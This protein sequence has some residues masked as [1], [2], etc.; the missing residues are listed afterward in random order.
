MMY[1]NPY[2]AGERVI[3][4]GAALPS[5]EGHEPKDFLIV[6]GLLVNSVLLDRT[7][8]T[9]VSFL[10][11]GMLVRHTGMSWPDVRP[12]AVVRTTVIELSEKR[13]WHEPAVRRAYMAQQHERLAKAEL[14]AACNAQH[15]LAG[16]CAQWLVQLRT[17]LGDVLPITHA[18]LATLLGV[19][20]AG[21]SVMLEALQRA[22]VVVLQ[23]GSIAITDPVRLAKFACPCP[24]PGIATAFPISVEVIAGQ[25]S[26]PMMPRSLVER[27]VPAVTGEGDRT[28]ARREAALRICQAVLSHGQMMLA[29]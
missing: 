14:I 3:M 17:Q 28:W 13:L 5:G 22:G 29:D 9:A 12:Q 23:R 11:P 20:R 27:E 1:A 6:S 25:A 8:P 2:F 21:I 24:T 16:R 4:A 10:P 7:P 26:P 15:S 18:F 19:R